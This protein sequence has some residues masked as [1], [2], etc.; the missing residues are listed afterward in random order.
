MASPASL[1]FFLPLDP[2]VILYVVPID[3]G[4]PHVVRIIS[5]GSPDEEKGA[6]FGNDRHSM[7]LVWEVIRCNLCVHNYTIS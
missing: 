4:Q 2:S 6:L 1:Q 3:L 7:Y 5:L